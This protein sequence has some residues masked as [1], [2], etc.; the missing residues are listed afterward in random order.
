MKPSIYLFLLLAISALLLT[1]V[2]LINYTTS[3]LKPVFGFSALR[4]FQYEQLSTSTGAEIILLG[5]SSLGCAIDPSMMEDITSQKTLKL[6][7]N[8]MYGFAGS[9][10]MLRQ[11]METQAPEAVLLMMTPG[12]LLSPP[13]WEGYVYSSASFRQ[14]MEAMPDHAGQVL[15]TWVDVLLT[16]GRLMSGIQRLLDGTTLKVDGPYDYFV[17]ENVA[18]DL[19]EPSL[20]SLGQMD[21]GNDFFL[22][23][24]KDLCDERQIKLILAF[25]PFPEYLYPKYQHQFDAQTAYLANLGISVIPP[26]LVE[27]EQL[28]DTVYHVRSAAVPEA[29]R[30]YAEELNGL[31]RK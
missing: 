21:D 22:K 10:N 25:S 3:F 4:I 18:G 11:S 19:G 8:G 17:P 15:K 16:S 5:D 7:L 29:T 26:Y 9:Y 24:I 30:R 12:A 20:L 13:S 2:V 1:S 23:Q 28:A 31:L 6:A 27:R 14:S